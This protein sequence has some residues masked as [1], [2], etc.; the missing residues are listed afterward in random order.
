MTKGDPIV[1]LV[2]L[3]PKMYSFTVGRSAEPIPAL[4]LSMDM[5]HK[6]VAYGV[7]RSQIK[8]F[9]HKDYVRMYNCGTLTNVVNSRIGSKFHKVRLTIF[10]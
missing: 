7:A 2:G 3:R 10:I 9:K 1:E 5:W 6:A 4:N 8:R